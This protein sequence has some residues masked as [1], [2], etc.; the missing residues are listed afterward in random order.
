MR[1]GYERGKFLNPDKDDSI[2]DI[3]GL[4]TLYK[5]STLKLMFDFYSSLA[6]SFA[7]GGKI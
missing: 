6:Q 7:N 2:K 1:S 3:S 5:E 4:Y